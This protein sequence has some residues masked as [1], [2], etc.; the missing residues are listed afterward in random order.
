MSKEFFILVKAEEG[1]FSNEKSVSFNTSDGK[2]VSLFANS[3]LLKTTN[4]GTEL[5]VTLVDTN[6]DTNINTVLLPSETFETSSR[7][8]EIKS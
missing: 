2:S 7:W 6:E 5:K 4:K 3:D 8:V 1:M